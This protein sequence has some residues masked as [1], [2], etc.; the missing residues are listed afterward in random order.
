MSKI[1]KDISKHLDVKTVNIIIG[2]IQKE[3]ILNSKKSALY[4]QCPLVY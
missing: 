3:K 1:F 4:V 2:N